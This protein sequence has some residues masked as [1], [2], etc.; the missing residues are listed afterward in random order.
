[1]VYGYHLR[2]LHELRFKGYF[3]L[4]KR[5][6]IPYFLLHSIRDMMQ[7]VREIKY[8]RL[9]HHGLIK[10]IFGDALNILNI[11]VPWSTFI[12]INREAFIGTQ[13]INLGQTPSSSLG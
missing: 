9:A 7:R 8:Q 5:L 13:A 1:M 4:G 10:L 11:L 12:D 2:L 6:K 3:P